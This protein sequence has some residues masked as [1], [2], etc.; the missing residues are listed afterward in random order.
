MNLKPRKHPRHPNRAHCL[1]H[2]HVNQRILRGR[3]VDGKREDE[4]RQ[5]DGRVVERVPPV[6]SFLMHQGFV[7]SI[8]A[9]FI[10]PLFENLEQHIIRPENLGASEAGGESDMPL[11]VVHRGH[12]DVIV[13]NKKWKQS[14]RCQRWSFHQ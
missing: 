11:G 10:R 5:D 14:L 3:E 1:L 8:R 4:G 9:K 7:S 13:L 12:A 2:K 6:S